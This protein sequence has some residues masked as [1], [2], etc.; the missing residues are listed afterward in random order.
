M[1]RFLNL[2]QLDH[3]KPAKYFLKFHVVLL[4]IYVIVLMFLLV[5][6]MCALFI[7]C[8]RLIITL[9]IG[10]AENN[11]HTLSIIFRFFPCRCA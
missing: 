7:L 3:C 2:D 6:I 5:K 9:C 1:F 4:T 11:K 10:H 8:E